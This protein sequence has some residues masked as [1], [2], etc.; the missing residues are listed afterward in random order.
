MAQGLRIDA[1]VMFVR[2]LGKSVDFYR[3]V[4]GL[5]VIDRTTTAALLGTDSGAQ[6]ILRAMGGTTPQT[7]GTVGV[8]YVVW[9]AASHDDLD[10]YEQ[11]LRA[12]SAFRERRSSKDGDAVEGHDPNDM[13]VMIIYPGPGEAPLREL[14]ARIYAW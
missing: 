7:L 11:L 13:V 9:T 4:L 2:D 14:P 5:Q 3:D 6:L 1:A 8:Q 10:R 12:R